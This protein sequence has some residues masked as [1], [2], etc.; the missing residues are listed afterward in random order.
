MWSSVNKQEVKACVTTLMI[1][2]AK[3]KHDFIPM[4]SDGEVVVQ[5]ITFKNDFK[6]FETI[7]DS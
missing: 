1:K 4:T 5:S 7:K 2:V 3:I 6:S